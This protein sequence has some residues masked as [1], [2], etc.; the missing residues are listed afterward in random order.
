MIETIKNLLNIFF[1]VVNESLLLF[2]FD[3]YS[4]FKIPW[5]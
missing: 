1:K 2:F 4:N 3:Y 5:Q